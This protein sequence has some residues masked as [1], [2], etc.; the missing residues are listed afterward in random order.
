[1]TRIVITELLGDGIGGELRESVYAVADALPLDFVFQ[2]LD[3]SLEGR[4]RGGRQLFEEVTATMRDTRVALKYPTVTRDVSPN[5]IIRRLCNFSVIL[6]P[7]ISIKGIKSNFKENVFLYIVRIATGGTYDDPGRRVGEDAAI[8]IRIVERVPCR[9][10]ANFAFR[11]A[12]EKGFKVTSSSKHTVQRVTDGLFQSIVDEVHKQFTDVPHNVELFDALLAKIVMHPEDFQVV[13]VLNEYGDFLSD[14]AS[15]LAGSIGNG[16]SGN[17][18][19]NDQDEI[20]IAMF[21]PSGGTAPDIAGQDKC[22]P[23][24]MLLAFGMLLDHIGHYAI[25]H[26]L[27][28]ALLGAIA[29]GE[30]TTDVGGR[31]GTREFVRT[32]VERLPREFRT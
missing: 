28:L 13:L 22:N 30:C 7:V 2:P 12:R 29:S 5:A 20:D 27:R 21:D 26:E 23:T 4:E 9:Q 19:F 32:V 16:A 11:F 15:G 14:M 25:G 10:A 24:G 18:S 6:R 8:S 17:F 31:M 1:M 3:L